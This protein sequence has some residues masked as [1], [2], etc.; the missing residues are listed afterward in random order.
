MTRRR[1]ESR[2]AETSRL[3]HSGDLTIPEIARILGVSVS[4]VRRDL[5]DS[6]RRTGRRK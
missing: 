3:Y 1:D 6:V 2:G 5:G 4:T